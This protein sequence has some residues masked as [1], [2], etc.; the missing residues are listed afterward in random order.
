MALTAFVGRDRDL[1]EVSKLIES[2]RLVTMMGSGGVGKSRLA[3]ETSAAMALRFD[4]GVSL[5]DLSGVADPALVWPAVAQVIGV[6]ERTEADL[7][8]RVIG[9]LRPQR[10]ILVLDNCEHLAAECTSIATQ[11]LG[12]CPGVRILATS[13]EGLGV[14]GEVTWCVPPLTFPCP[15]YPPALHELEGFGAVALFA[16]RARAA[17]PDLVIGADDI[18]ALSSI[19]RNLDGIPLA[20]ELAAARVSALS[21][22][23]IAARLDGRFGLLSRR[24]PGPARH[25]TLQ[26]S[27]DWS[28]QLLSEPE[29][30]LF[31]RL[32]VFAVSWSLEAA[33]AVGAGPPIGPGE[34]AR[35]LAAL[36]DKSLV[37]AEGTATG[38]RYRLLKA[39][40]AF[41]GDR[42]AASGELED[43]QA[44]HGLYFVDLGSHAASGLHD[45]NQDQWAWLLDQE[46][47]NLR[48][49][50]AWCAAD[51][52]RA[53]P[54][55][56]LASCLW[57]YW[58]IRGLLEE[59]K[60]WLD[61]ALRR[62]PDPAQG[63]ADALT[64]LAVI[65][66][67]RGG[68]RWGGKL[69][70]ESIVLHQK[71][72]DER[73]EAR[74]LALLGFWQAN[75]GDH[76]GAAEALARAITLA[77]P[78]RDRYPAAFAHL[79]AA[80]A[81][82]LLMDTALARTH[83][84]E[85][86][87]LFTRIGDLRA[88]GYARCVLA[89]CLVCEGSPED[90]LVILRSCMGRFEAMHDRWGLLISTG[91]VARAY[92]ALGDWRR[93]AFA[94]GITESLSA[95]IGGNLF[96]GM[97]RP[98]DAVAA[99]I[100]MRLGAAAELEAGRSAGHSDRLAAALDLFMGPEPPEP[101]RQEALLTKREGQIAKLIAGGLTNRQIAE[102]LF[103][104]LRTVDTHVGHILA[105]LG[106]SN[107]SQVT[108]FSCTGRIPAGPA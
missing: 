2:N 53:V 30:A 102:R 22:A 98:V 85:C 3:I 33:E 68:F 9:L 77:R 101:S 46:Q 10:R 32:A 28:Y 14:Q 62:A 41:A 89:D 59:G 20:L 17:R 97:Q 25:Q 96:P 88:A 87:D 44:K 24:G 82:A 58:L 54:G 73:G 75:Q 65:T 78:L 1:C 84:C 48:A 79:M 45:M 61:D 74:A 95:R 8:S 49:A 55:L 13:R 63:R 60:A 7:A 71:S 76:D 57:E 100:A 93:A 39:I 35:L 4:D 31:R 43:L 34:A 27:V 64:G 23:E 42:L 103:I 70:A 66:G 36:V 80:M 81:V 5:I 21:L 67:L 47:A 26:A 92:A 51:P 19:C 29:R 69:L 104:A 12:Y 15:E 105:K 6:E 56:K 94:L 18:A 108:A 86:F 83:A 99:K 16:E 38:T 90:A 50:R 40:R 11:I 37:Q 106:C 72:G 91:M 107:R 52:G